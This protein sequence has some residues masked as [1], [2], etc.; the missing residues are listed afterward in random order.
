MFLFK[1]H[2][3]GGNR[4]SVDTY[5]SEFCPICTSAFCSIINCHTD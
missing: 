2:I 1:N 5:I 3:S 4:L